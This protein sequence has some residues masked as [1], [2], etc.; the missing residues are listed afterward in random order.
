[1]VFRKLREIKGKLDNY[2]NLSNHVDKLKEDLIEAKSSFPHEV[3][4]NLELAVEKRTHEL[5]AL[6]D[7]YDEVLQENSDLKYELSKLKF[8][9]GPEWL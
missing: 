4:H 6:K 5:N 2:D 8:K 1:M 3:I 7:K 9:G